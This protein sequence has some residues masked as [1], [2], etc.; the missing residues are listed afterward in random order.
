MIACRSDDCVVLIGCGGE[1]RVEAV[2][3]EH[4]Q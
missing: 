4:G 3:D 1:S 2:V